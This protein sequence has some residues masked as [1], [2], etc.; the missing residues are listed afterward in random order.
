MNLIKR[1]KDLMY[2]QTIKNKSP[3]WLLTEI[4]VNKGEKL[5][6]RYGL[7]EQIIVSSLYLAHTIFNPIWKSEIQKNHTHL[8]A[9]FVKPILNQWRV[10]QKDQEIIINSIEAHHGD[11]ETETKEAEIVKNAKCYKFITLEGAKIYF[12]ELKKRGDHEEEAKRKVIEKM[13]T[14][15]KLLT[16][17]ECIKEASINCKKIQEEFK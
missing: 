13:K 12:E 15:K 10:D 7:D 4:A 1:S 5:A 14:K 3:T 9:N 8:S 2:K 16:L 17:P 11:I 6:L